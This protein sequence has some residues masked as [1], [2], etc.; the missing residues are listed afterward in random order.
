MRLQTILALIATV[1][2][3]GT[4][5]FGTTVTGMEHCTWPRLMC[6]TSKGSLPGSGIQGLC[7]TLIANGT[8]SADACWDFVWRYTCAELLDM[9][10]RSGSSGG[11]CYGFLFTNCCPTPVQIDVSLTPEIRSDQQ[12]TAMWVFTNRESERAEARA[13]RRQLVID[14]GRDLGVMWIGADDKFYIPG[15]ELRWQVHGVR[16]ADGSPARP[17]PQAASNHTGPY[18]AVAYDGGA[19]TF[20][21]A[22]RT[23]IAADRI[24]NEAGTISFWIEPQWSRSDQRNADFVDLGTTGLQIVKRGAALWFQYTNG[25]GEAGDADVAHWEKGERHHVVAIW[26]AASMEL[27]IDG[28]QAFLSQRG[29]RAPVPEAGGVFI[30][31][32]FEDDEASAPAR[33]STIRIMNYNLSFQEVLDLYKRG[34]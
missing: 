25:D 13:Q 14:A 31:A 23:A 7:E 20:E 27:Y 15:A 8:T 21:T 22:H 5:A 1:L 10:V 11:N 16:D 9:Q 2:L 12:P 24:R 4:S 26:S 33:I 19:R 3:N 29:G 34:V 28:Q 32:A 18:P 30:G 6:P 17:T